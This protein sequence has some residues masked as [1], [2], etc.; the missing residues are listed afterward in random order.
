VTIASNWYT[1]NLED[2]EIAYLCGNC[3]EE[4]LS[5][6]LLSEHMQNNPTCAAALEMA[7]DEYLVMEVPPVTEGRIADK[8]LDILQ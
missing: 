6:E 3:T 2:C 8:N 5:E 7:E 1:T 4:F